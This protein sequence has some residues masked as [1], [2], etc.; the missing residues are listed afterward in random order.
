MKDLKIFYSIFLTN[1]LKKLIVGVLDNGDIIL[2][3]DI[4]NSKEQEKWPMALQISLKL[5]FKNLEHISNLC[6]NISV[7]KI[8]SLQ[9][10][11]AISPLFQNFF[12]CLYHSERAD[13]IQLR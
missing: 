7:S 6:Y 1:P 3:K 5:P 13:K 9:E 2:K 12:C 8:L 11:Y 10:S 4:K